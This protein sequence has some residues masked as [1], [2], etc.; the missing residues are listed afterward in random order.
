MKYPI[1]LISLILLSSC[2]QSL[3]PTDWVVSIRGY[4]GETEVV[5]GMWV[6]I[7]EDRVLTSAHVVREDRLRYEVWGMRYEVWERDFST[8]RAYLKTMTNT[9]TLPREYIWKIETLTIWEKISI[10]VIRSGSLITLTGSITSLTG[11]RLAYDSVG[12]TQMLSWLILTDISL[13]PWDSGAPILDGQGRVIDV[14]H[15]AE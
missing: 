6:C 9:C 7:A 10:P 14:V 15:V 13:L 2:G 4:R 5:R 8:D 1:S 3:S 11:T 12:R